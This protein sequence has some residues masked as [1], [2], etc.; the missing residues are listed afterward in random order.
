M[1]V[2][3]CARARVETRRPHTIV[4]GRWREIRR[5]CG[6]VTVRV[7]SESPLRRRVWSVASLD[8]K[9][10]FSGTIIHYDG[11]TAMSHFNTTI[12]FNYFIVSSR[13]RYLALTR[14]I[15]TIGII[16]F[17]FDRDSITE[18]RRRHNNSDDENNND[19]RFFITRLFRLSLFSLS[20][21]R[22]H[23]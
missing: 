1:Y 6:A 16:I 21:T 4:F 22:H 15:D 2:C 17:S 8:V 11:V 7:L 10:H 23:Y 3:E 13:T 5:A 19:N 14:T 12:Y 9:W 18:Y 20:P